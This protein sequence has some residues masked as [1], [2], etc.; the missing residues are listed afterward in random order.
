MDGLT[1]RW[2][3]VTCGRVEAPAGAP[4][5]LPEFLGWAAGPGWSGECGVESVDAGGDL[6]G[7][8]PGAVDA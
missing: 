4:V 8:A 7:P 5:R 6:G 2:W 3:V 1:V